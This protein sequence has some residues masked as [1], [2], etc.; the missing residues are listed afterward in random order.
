MSDTAKVFMSG[1]S[2]AVRIPAEYRVEGKELRIRK[3]GDAL[4]LEPLEA[5]EWAWLDEL[6]PVDAEFSRAMKAR[7]RPVA[8]GR[9]ALK[10]AFK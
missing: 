2:Q 4:I 5:D 6:D 10:R 8:Q 9:P 7:P 3:Q 1:G